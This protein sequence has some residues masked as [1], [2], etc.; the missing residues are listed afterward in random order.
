MKDNKKD[1]NIEA[2]QTKKQTNPAM[3]AQ[4][5]TEDQARKW[6]LHVLIIA[7]AAMS[8]YALYLG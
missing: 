4:T 1:W 8:M 7:C 5:E 2:K 6:F 3:Q